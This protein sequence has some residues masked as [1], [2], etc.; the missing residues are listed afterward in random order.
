MGVLGLA[1]TGGPSMRVQSAG[2]P[3]RHSTHEGFSGAALVASDSAARPGVF[4]AR[5]DGPAVAFVAVFTVGVD[6]VDP[7]A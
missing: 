1:A 5:C 3:M 6:L 4:R 7:D 2:K